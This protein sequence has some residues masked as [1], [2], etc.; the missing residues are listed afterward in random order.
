MNDDLLIDVSRRRRDLEVTI[1]EILARHDPMGL[2]R[3]GAPNHEYRPEAAFMA[4]WLMDCRGVVEFIVVKN[5][6]YGTFCHLFD[7]ASVGTPD[8]YEAAAQEIFDA[9]QAWRTKG[10]A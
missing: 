1:R 9:W 6:L 5:E 8:H 7:S 2:I 4:E 3:M 10:K